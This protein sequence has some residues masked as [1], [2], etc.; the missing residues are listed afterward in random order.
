MAKLWPFFYYMQRNSNH[1]EE[2]FDVDGSSSL[3]VSSAD[4]TNGTV[5]RGI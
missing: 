2:T 3:Q 4:F 5:S 1:Y